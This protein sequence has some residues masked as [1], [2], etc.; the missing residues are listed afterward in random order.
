[1]ANPWEEFGNAEVVPADAPAVAP[2][3]SPTPAPIEDGPWGDFEEPAPLP[4]TPD[5]TNT[6]EFIRTNLEN[7]QAEQA[8]PSANGEAKVAKTWLDAID[9]GWQRSISGLADRK[10]SPDMVMDEHADLFLSLT[11]QAATFVGDIPAM[12][13]GEIAGTSAGAAAG[14][15]VPVAG[16]AVGAFAGGAAGAFGLPAA[17]RRYM[18]DSYAK[19]EY[20]TPR[21]YLAAA[22]AAMLD[23]MKEGGIGVLTMGLGRKAGLVTEGMGKMAS[24]IAAKAT[25]AATLTTASAAME[26]H[27][28][29]ARGLAEA[30][31]FITGMHGFHTVK[32]KLENVYTKANVRP[33]EVAMDTE[34]DP[35]IKQDLIGDKDNYVPRAYEEMVQA[36]MELKPKAQGEFDLEPRKPTLEERRLELAQRFD[37]KA[38]K[39]MDSI[40][41]RLS[42]L[43][44]KRIALE[45]KMAMAEDLTTPEEQS[46]V[47]AELSA[48]N[49]ELDRAIQA[50]D[51]ITNRVNKA[52]EHTKPLTEAT[53]EERRAK[54]SPENELNQLADEYANREF[55]TPETTMVL[56]SETAIQSEFD[57][58][59]TEQMEF[60]TKEHPE[61]NARIK[62]QKAIKTKEAIQDNLTQ[63]QKDMQSMIGEVEGEKAP[64]YLE[65]FLSLGNADSRM[66]ARINLIDRLHALE[67]RQKSRDGTDKVSVLQNEYALAEAASTYTGKVEAMLNYG[68]FSHA[69]FTKKTSRGFYEIVGK[70]AKEITE[71]KLFM[72]AERGLEL[73]AA[74]KKVGKKFNADSA[75][76]VVA[77][78]QGKYGKRAAELRQFENEVLRYLKDSGFLSEEQFTAITDANKYHLPM[79]RVNPKDTVTLN[80]KIRKSATKPIKEYIGSEKDIIDPF[81]SILRN[82]DTYVR[83]AEQQRAKRAF[84]MNEE[85]LPLDERFIE[86]VGVAETP[87]GDALEQVDANIQKSRVSQSGE[88]FTFTLVDNGKTR[89]FKTTKE[90]YDAFQ[91]LGGTEKSASFLFKFMRGITKVKRAGIT[92]MPDYMIKNMLRDYQTG[93]AFIE[94]GI[95]T[96]AELKAAYMD[97]TGKTQA[98]QDYLKSGGA[99]S[100]QLESMGDYVDRQIAEL[101]KSTGTWDL[102]WSTIR[103]AADKMA[104]FGEIGEE[105][106]RLVAF[107]RK[108]GANPTMESIVAGGKASKEATVDF[109]KVGAKLAILRSVTAFQ[110]AQIQGADRYVRAL[111]KD[112]EAFKAIPEMNTKDTINWFKNSTI[113][114]SMLTISVPTLLSWAISR[115]D[116]RVDNLPEYQR[117]Q[118]LT[119]PINYWDKIT[120]EEASTIAPEYTRQNADGSWEVNKGPII[121]LPLTQEGGLFFGAMFRKTLEKLDKDNPVH[122]EAFAKE[123]I[124]MFTPTVMPDALSPIVEMATN[125]SMFTGNKLVPAYLESRLPEDIQTPNTSE[126]AKGLSSVIPVVPFID[127]TNNPLNP[128]VVDNWIKSWTGTAGGY[129]IALLDGTIHG[130]QKAKAGELSSPM[131]YVSALSLSDI[132]LVKSFVYRHPSMGM[133]PIQ[134]FY[135][136]NAI[137][138]KVSASLEARKAEGDIEGINKLLAEY[139]A[140]AAAAASMKQAAAAMSAMST[141][142]KGINKSKELTPTE[143]VNK[144]QGAYYMI[145]GTARTVLD[146]YKELK[147]NVAK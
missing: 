67:A 82:V 128:I 129:A 73:E 126:L 146:Q 64:T 5:N 35:T 37:P 10:K 124:G 130:M 134:D 46:K 122:A 79:Y 137:V 39:D 143:K 84:V 61:L 2:S 7:F 141:V 29:T 106:T 135:N 25:E 121:R 107:K 89:T 22:S 104:A 78:G 36:E 133:Q 15:V 88:D 99:H 74:G 48:V 56:K 75:R 103:T 142:V 120:A 58:G 71:L 95:I 51:K 33:E 41:K 81:E 4:P 87:V 102:G 132:P 59:V 93:S 3:P 60:L 111:G 85:K 18:M 118:A 55:V 54:L 68:V 57:L 20:K 53:W 45:E 30:S 8:A 24:T 6:Q 13:V 110:G 62:E 140:E 65:R 86:E 27:L 44:E 91:T 42:E 40:E 138:Q 115:D 66:Q 139:P 96:A 14:S 116:K 90:I 31:L 26:G 32:S 113:A 70:D 83:M 80:G 109:S 100:T 50:S 76:E 28:P 72:M 123:I 77:D 52:Y 17:M 43:A 147:N 117:N 101:N 114:K 131:E 9:A 11:S 12:M 23:G 19:G 98:Y 16:T 1:M 63:A 34:T 92:M 112:A 108:A 94:G 144:G 125:K 145:N 105:M 127:K 47:A 69:D 21:E 38:F 119:I 49:N 97:I 136:E